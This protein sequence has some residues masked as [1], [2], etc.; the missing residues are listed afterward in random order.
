MQRACG[1]ESVEHCQTAALVPLCAESS[2]VTS[3]DIL[4]YRR[5]DSI[6]QARLRAATTFQD[7]YALM[8]NLH[9]FIFAFLMTLGFSVLHVTLA[10]SLQLHSHFTI[11]SA[12]LLV[13]ASL[14][15][16]TLCFFALD[17]AIYTQ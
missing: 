8:G 7:R 3:W 15:S 17:E 2:A 6:F 16:M 9:G 4:F 10:I 1:G 14:V 13:Y 5:I 11:L 12:C